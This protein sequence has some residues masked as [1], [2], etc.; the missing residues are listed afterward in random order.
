M[1]VNRRYG[2]YGNK[3]NSMFNLDLE[4]L[5]NLLI[6]KSAICI[7][8]HKYVDSNK[9]TVLTRLEIE[10]EFIMLYFEY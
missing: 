7:D 5:N 9:N 6:F 10:F 1:Q 4:Q 2:R 3:M 8:Q